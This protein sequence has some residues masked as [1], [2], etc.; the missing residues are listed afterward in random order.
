MVPLSDVCATAATA[1]NSKKLIKSKFRIMHHLFKS[2]LAIGL[3]IKGTMLR[4]C[5]GTAK[6]LCFRMSDRGQKNE[7]VAFILSKGREKINLHFR[8]RIRQV[9]DS[10]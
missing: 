6:T 9:N 5:V 7:S 8:Q 2:T 1:D 3:P 10:F 4:K